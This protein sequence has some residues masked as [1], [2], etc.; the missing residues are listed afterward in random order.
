M[1]TR[2]LAVTVGGSIGKCGRLSQPNWLLVRTSHT[3]LLTHLH[4]INLKNGSEE[5]MTLLLSSGIER[6][7][8]WFG[9]GSIV[10][11][12]DRFS[13]SQEHSQRPSQQHLPSFSAKPDQSKL[14]S[15]RD[16]R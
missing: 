12:V 6:S 5:M 7:C 15:D 1:T 10:G 16:P 4:N 8:D 11:G 13:H 3:Y 14:T 2:C 9:T